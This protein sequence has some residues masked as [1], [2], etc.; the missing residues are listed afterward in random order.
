MDFEIVNAII[1]LDEARYLFDIEYDI[2]VECMT[3]FNYILWSL[4]HQAR[5]C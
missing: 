1:G 2:F 4:N 5:A 3:R